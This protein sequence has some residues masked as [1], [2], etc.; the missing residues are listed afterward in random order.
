M[1]DTRDLE[2]VRADIDAIDQDIQALLNRRAECAQRVAAI[3]L[4][5]VAQAHAR[6]ETAAEVVF[7]R[8]ERE[9]Q[10]LERI[11]RRN[12]GPLDGASVAHIFRE[13][14]SAC[15]ALEKPLQVAYL[16]PEGTFTQGATI[17]HFGHAAICVPQTTID[18]VF[19]QVESG[20]CN[21]GVV[22]VE[23][24][25]EGMVSH[26]L[27]NFMDSSLKISGEVEMRIGLHLLVTP[28]TLA[29]DVKRICA[30]QQA[31]AQCRNWLDK[32]WPHVER[33][34]VSS[35][36]EAARMAAQ[37]PGVAAVAGDM[38]AELYQLEKLAT[39]I[40]DYADNTTR[41]LIIGREEVPPSGRDK[42]SIIVSSR[43]KP[44]ALFTLLE[45][46]RRGNVSLTRIDTRPSRTEKWAYVFFIE[47]EGHLQDPK[48]A[49]I[50]AELEEQSI[51]LKP[52]GSYPQALL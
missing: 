46:F 33:E 3:K 31:L 32:H 18:A 16:G 26:T 45:P 28:G 25:T 23:N 22:P 24:S 48:I 52:L 5:E 12:T 38:A 35:N 49:A 21:Y 10:V 13:I 9:A 20:E 29:S 30:H 47:F 7:Y 36:G 6:G 51:M 43:N 14:M 19:S 15:L 42:T 1:A 39:N 4:A 2:Q 34:A 40:E 44:G 37:V 27:D 41:F 17:K 11:I 50:V 8:P